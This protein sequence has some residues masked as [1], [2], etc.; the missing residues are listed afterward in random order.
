[1]KT[2]VEE[3][4]EVKRKI[5]VEIDAEEVTKSIDKA[6]NQLSRKAKVKG[7][8][9][10]K[11]PRKILEQYYG[12]QVV[13][14][15]KS[16]LIRE[17][18]PKVLDETKL[19]P[20]GEPSIEDELINPDNIFRYAIFMEVKPKFEI[21]NYMGISV[22][23]EVL[24]ISE[25]TVDKSIEKMRKSHA[26]L[27]S[28]EEDRGIIEQDRVIINYE[29]FWKDKPIK[30]IKGQEF[31]VHVG[32]GNF[33]KEIES[34]IVGLKKGDEKDI[35]INFDENFSDSRLAGKLVNFNIV[36][37]DIKEEDLPELN[38]DFAKVLGD[39]FE[40]LADLRQ[41]V[42]EEITLQEE[43]RIDSELKKRLIGKISDSVNFE[44]PQILV[45]SEINY[46]I[47]SLKEGF[48][49]NG[50]TMESTGISE[51]KM[52]QELIKPSEEKIKEE[53]VLDAIA[54]IEAITVEEKDI[55]DAF[56]GL[57]GRTGSD[58]ALIRQYYESN[59]LMN[60]FEAQI[61]AEKTL[62]HLVKGA[63]INDVKEIPKETENSERK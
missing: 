56:D 6:Y 41:K 45:E 17:S 35:E 27:I 38:D 54:R 28:I 23:K 52:R 16:D 61:L 13:N 11:A 50:M 29:G 2:R 1:M 37:I 57:S 60:S 26:R 32:S 18:F 47:N 4:S 3:I 40:S 5:N 46:S 14:D 8:R 22:D 7:F 42:T 62:N 30:D 55:G 49:Q 33:Y 19:F 20:L 9:P 48:S 31:M 24:N 63:I 39:D 34:G 51:S 59:N 58:P 10:G 36:I 25:E 43:K 53:L 15:V 21:K 12:K 44:L